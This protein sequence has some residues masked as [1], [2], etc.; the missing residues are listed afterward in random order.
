MN[1]DND[2]VQDVEKSRERALR[3]RYGLMIVLPAVFF[4]V[5]T[6]G[7]RPSILLIVGFVALDI[8][9][10]GAYLLLMHLTGLAVKLPPAV[11]R[12]IYMLAVVMPVLLLMLQSLGQLTIRDTVTLAGLFILGIFYVGRLRAR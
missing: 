4:A 2:I 12:S 3:L 11:R 5:T 1:P 10:S 8:M 9:L 7:P 6:P